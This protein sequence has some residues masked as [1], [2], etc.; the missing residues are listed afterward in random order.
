MATFTTKR[1]FKLKQAL[2]MLESNTDSDPGDLSDEDFDS[3]AVV[4]TFILG[5]SWLCH[6]RHGTASEVAWYWVINRNCDHLNMS[7]TS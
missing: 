5:K 1:R 6:C 4:D 3:P 7:Y 2:E